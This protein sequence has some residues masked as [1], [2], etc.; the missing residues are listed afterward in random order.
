MHIR[1]TVPLLTAMACFVPMNAAQRSS[2]SAVRRP[3]ASMP[4]WRT[5]VTAAI[6]SAPMSGRAT[7]ITR[8]LPAGTG[9]GR[10]SSASSSR[11]KA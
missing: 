8:R 10:S 6:S 9:C 11:A 1:A 7:G 2:S 4:L 3:P 5:S